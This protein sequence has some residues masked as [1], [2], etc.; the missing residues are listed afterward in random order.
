MQLSQ[1]L[2]LH[3]NSFCIFFFLIYPGLLCSDVKSSG[4]LKST[5]ISVPIQTELKS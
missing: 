1:K 2:L 5:D 3:L 4:V